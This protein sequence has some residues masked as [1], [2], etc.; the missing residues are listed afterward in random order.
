MKSKQSV[1]VISV[2]G[3]GIK[4]SSIWGCAGPTLRFLHPW[5]AN[6]K[7]MLSNLAIAAFKQQ[8][9]VSKVVYGT[10]HTDLNVSVSL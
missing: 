5:E 8:L 10:I 2:L 3:A 6:V 1:L 7:E 9:N 4:I